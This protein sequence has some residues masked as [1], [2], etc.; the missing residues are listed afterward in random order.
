MTLKHVSFS[1]SPTCNIGCSYCKI[2]D[3]PLKRIS[4]EMVKEAFDWIEANSNDKVVCYLG[5]KEP[6]TEFKFIQQIV[7]LSRNYS[8][9]KPR[10]LTNGVLLTEEKL[11]WLQANKDHI[12]VQMSLDGNIK[13]NTSRKFKTGKDIFGAI[14]YDLIFKKYKGVVSNI[15]CTVNLNNAATLYDDVK[16]FI[17]DL[18]VRLIAFSLWTD[19][20]WP[21]ELVNTLDQQMALI[22]DE[23]IKRIRTADWFTVSNFT[24]VFFDGNDY[25]REKCGAGID[26]IV[27]DEEGFVHSCATV[28]D[29]VMETYLPEYKDKPKAD[30]VQKHTNLGNIKTHRYDQLAGKKLYQHEFIKCDEC[31]IQNTCL[32]CRVQNEIYN[33]DFAPGSCEML[34]VMDKWNRIASRFDHKFTQ[35]EHHEGANTLFSHDEIKALAQENVEPEKIKMIL[36]NKIE[37]EIL[38]S[39]KTMVDYLGKMK[40][41]QD[42]IIDHLNIPKPV[43]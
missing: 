40:Q 20:V 6:L 36:E 23:Y 38:N 33:I 41:T 13:G 26:N 3:M 17:D 29:G 2:K 37:L 4:I 1:V 9:I 7:D 30:W 19:G 11:Q 32:K 24:R 34:M 14:D 15:S 25:T 42:L 21:M 8:R 16:F 35:L 27:I 10:L 28:L 39:L 22:Y 31:P 5:Y 12:I 43:Q 18:Q